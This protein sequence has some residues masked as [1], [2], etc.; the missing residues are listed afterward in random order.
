MAAI[1]H[2]VRLGDDSSVLSAQMVE[3]FNINP[4]CQSQLVARHIEGPHIH[5]IIETIEIDPVSIFSTGPQ[6]SIDQRSMITTAG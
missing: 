6:R 5:M 1:R 4:G 2:S 3:A